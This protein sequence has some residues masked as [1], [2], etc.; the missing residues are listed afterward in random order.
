VEPQAQPGPG[1][2]PSSLQLAP[3]AVRAETEYPTSSRRGPTIQAATTKA[4]KAELAGNYDTAFKFNID[5]AQTYLYL[6]RNTT[7][8]GT[9]AQLRAVS[10]KVLER[11]ERIKQ[12]KHIKPAE[13]SKLGAG[14]SRSCLRASMASWLS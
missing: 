11:A 7:N 4:A 13:Q 6:T 10:A 8:E 2:P 9:K 12:A 5:A 3:E 14:E 1:E